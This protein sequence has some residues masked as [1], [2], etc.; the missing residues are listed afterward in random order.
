[1]FSQP[2]EPAEAIGYWQERARKAESA[3]EKIN[4]IRDQVIRTQ[5]L[6]WSSVMYPL[7][8]A[9]DEAG[10]ASTVTDADLER[11]PLGNRLENTAT[12]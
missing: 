11:A 12:E 1:M 8:Q 4:A 7:V 2:I 6:G 9:L 5:R 10:I 3:L